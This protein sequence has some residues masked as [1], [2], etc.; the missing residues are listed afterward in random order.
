MHRLALDVGL[1]LD[2][3]RRRLEGRA[4]S[5][6]RAR[7]QWRRGVARQPPL[8]EEVHQLLLADPEFAREFVCLHARTYDYAG[9]GEF[10]TSG[11][12]AYEP[13]ALHKS[14]LSVPPKS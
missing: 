5:L 10:D 3:A 1:D 13:I 7:R 9:R 11:C 14:A 6:D 12:R 4:G 8:L 2:R